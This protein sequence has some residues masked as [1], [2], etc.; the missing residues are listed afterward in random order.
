MKPTLV[1]LAAGVGSRYGG[2]KQLEPVG[3]G[4]ESLM[5][6]SIFD[7][8]CAGFGRVVLVVRPETEAEFRRTIGARVAD[9]LPVFYVHQTLDAL[10]P[11]FE[12]PSGR[13]KPWGTGQ[14]VLVAEPEVDGPFAVVNA[15]DFYGGDAYAVLGRFLGQDA[16]AHPPTFAMAAF[17]VGPTLSESGPVS[18]GLCRVDEDGFLEEI[19]EILELWKQGDGG[20]Y[21]DA[22]GE[23]RTVEFDEAVS[24]NMWG[25]SP[26]IFDEL[27]T[28]FSEFMG[29]S[30][31]TPSAEFLLP[32]VVQRMIRER[33]ARVRVLRHGS[34]WCGITYPEDRAAAEGMIAN[35][36]SEGVYPPRLWE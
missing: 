26:A 28:A 22:D 15:D 19:V 12:A 24:M 31:E 1:I 4:G 20:L 25:F 23:G 5:E 36:V 16:V 14:A 35:L 29:N 11:G 2:L 32:D 18:R 8:A 6:Y 7:A 34:Q 30:L 33:R 3:P 9:R 10:P 13:T 27:R 17:E 21:L